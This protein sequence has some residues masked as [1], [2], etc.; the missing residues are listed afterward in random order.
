[1]TRPVRFFLHRNRSN[2]TR[3][4][5]CLYIVFNECCDLLGN[6]FDCDRTSRWKRIFTPTCS[7]IVLKKCVYVCVVEASSEWFLCVR[8]N[9][10]GIGLKVSF[11]ASFPPHKRSALE[12]GAHF[13]AVL[14]FFFRKSRKIKHFFRKRCPFGW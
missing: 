3:S 4:R 6:N 7:V 1:M 2:Q 9:V 8:E 10:I 13:S 12:E 11:S 14:L 5:H